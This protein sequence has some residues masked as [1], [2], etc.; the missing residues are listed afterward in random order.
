MEKSGLN[1]YF[2]DIFISE[3]ICA[4]KPLSAFFDYVRDHIPNWNAES[5]LVV[6]DSLTSDIQG[7]INYGLD[8]CWYNPDQLPYTLSQPCN[9]VISS[10]DELKMIVK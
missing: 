9:Y 8:S 2:E 4:Q 3:E 10:F 7:A 1:A 6:G 5:T